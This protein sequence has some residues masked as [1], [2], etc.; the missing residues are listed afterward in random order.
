MT[1]TWPAGRSPTR[2]SRLEAFDVVWVGLRSPCSPSRSPTALLSSLLIA[3]DVARSRVL[4]AVTRGGPLTGI[5]VDAAEPDISALDS[6]VPSRKGPPRSID[7][8][9]IRRIRTLPRGSVGEPGSDSSDPHR[10]PRARG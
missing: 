2:C 8:R 7:D 9:A 6:D 3:G 10:H 5:K 1:A 4:D